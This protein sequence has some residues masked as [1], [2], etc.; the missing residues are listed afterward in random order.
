MM[1]NKILALAMAGATGFGTMGA[2]LAP[3]SA[4]SG[5]QTALSSTS[6]PVIQVQGVSQWNAGEGR[7][8]LGPNDS[9][10]QPDPPR[11][12]PRRDRPNRDNDGRNDRAQRRDDGDRYAR[13]RY[14]DNRRYD[15]RRYDNRR[16][17]NPNWR[18][19]R[20]YYQG[21]YWR[22][23]NDGWYVYNDGAWIAAGALGLAAGAM[24]GSAMAQQPQPQG[25]IQS[26]APVT[27]NGIPP[28]TP[29]W[30]QYCSG[31]YKSFNAQTGLYL[32]YDGKYH[33][34]R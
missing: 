7:T 25:T 15:N 27:A 21:R 24:L 33:Y 20:R 17:Y 11:A 22:P 34:C 12:E 2:T 13:D 26:A 3:A 5:V 9:R 32:G 14:H 19:E 28:W 30:Y 29:A 8:Y 18:G 4:M 23:A 16:N 10:G 31:K 6:L 1:K